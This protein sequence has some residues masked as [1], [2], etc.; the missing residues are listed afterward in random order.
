MSQEFQT[1][2]ASAAAVAAANAARWHQG[3]RLQQTQPYGL[4][5]QPYGLPQQLVPQQPVT[6]P[7]VPSREPGPAA[8]ATVAPDASGTPDHEGRPQLLQQYANLVQLTQQQAHTMAAE[9]E[10][11]RVVV[12][13]LQ[14]ARAACTEWQERYD[15]LMA[16]AH[17]AEVRRA[18]AEA[19]AK[20]AEKAAKEREATIAKLEEQAAEWRKLATDM[21]K[22]QKKEKRRERSGSED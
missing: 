8:H 19:N 5:Q 18:V 6:M 21:L 9:V 15:A 12:Q 20:A 7:M 1:A 22:E 3:G 17:D 16:K 4:L 11:R 2:V 13:E 10:S 14:T